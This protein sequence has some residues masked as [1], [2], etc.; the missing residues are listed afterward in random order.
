MGISPLPNEQ[1]NGECLD[2]GEADKTQAIE[3]DSGRRCEQVGVLSE[4]RVLVY[5]HRAKAADKTSKHS[6][7]FFMLNVNSKQAPVLKA[8][9]FSHDVGKHFLTFLIPYI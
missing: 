9:V 7:C 5:R 6:F 4:F 2:T 3:E 1:G 8:D